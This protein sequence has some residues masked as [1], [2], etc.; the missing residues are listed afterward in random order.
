MSLR[1]RNIFADHDTI[2]SFV[3]TTVMNF[4]NIFTINDSYF[5]LASKPRFRNENR[6]SKCV[7]D[8]K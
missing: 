2:T 5:S 6:T 7:R 3:T 4:E 8:T 1:N